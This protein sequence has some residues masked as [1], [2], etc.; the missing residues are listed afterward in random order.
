M[1]KLYKANIKLLLFL[2]FLVFAFSTNLIAQV[3]KTVPSIVPLPPPPTGDDAPPY[4]P[5]T[6]NPSTYNPCGLIENNTFFR[7]PVN[8]N[9]PNDPL[10]NAAPFVSY[11]NNWTSSHGTPQIN[12]NTPQIAQNVNHASMWADAI[13][14]AN[15]NLVQSGEGIATGIHQLVPNNNYYITFSKRFFQGGGAGAGVSIDDYYIVLLSCA[16]FQQI[17]RYGEDYTIPAIPSSAQII[18]HESNTTNTNWQ[19]VTQT[20]TANSNYD[21]VWIFPKNHTAAGTTTS[22]TSWLE[23]AQPQIKSIAAC[24]PPPPPPPPCSDPTQI[25]SILPN[26]TQ[27]HGN[28]LIPYSIDNNKNNVVCYPWEWDDK[29]KLQSSFPTNNT[30]YL[31]GIPIPQQVIGTGNG[32]EFLPLS[33]CMSATANICQSGYQL[34]PIEIKVSNPNSCNGMSSPIKVIF[35]PLY[36]ATEG[37]FSIHPGQSST[38]NLFDYGSGSNFTWHN[39][40]AGVT[41]TPLN[42]NWSSVSVFVPFSY[43]SANLYFP[44]DVINPLCSSSS[45]NNSNTVC[46]NFCSSLFTCWVQVASSFAGS[47]PS[48]NLLSRIYPNPGTDQI[49]ISSTETI[50]LIEISD[51]LSPTLKRIKVNGIKSTTINVFDLKPG[52]YNCKIT[53]NKG[54]ENQKLIIKR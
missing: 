35:N 32:N 50:N 34:T 23:I 49:T 48:S 30:W 27:I 16:Q 38:L 15:G 10:Y 13:L 28:N 18:Y 41:I 9:N 24:G 12:I 4:I 7:N 44:I 43:A 6:C 45:N 20:F 1:K 2:L 46:I 5:F 37:L 54:I 25:L 22:I 11:I 3:K 36:Y 26:A 53:T 19:S 47:S 8:P 29:L 21:V 33:R 17:R 31:N 39:N 52:V 40:Y 42:A 14:D 51:L